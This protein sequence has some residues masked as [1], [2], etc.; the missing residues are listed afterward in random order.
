MIPRPK[1]EQGESSTRVRYE[2]TSGYP[3]HRTDNI[4]RNQYT[5]LEK[6]N[7]S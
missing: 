4:D 6:K 3:I 1:I 5:P 7:E 2:P